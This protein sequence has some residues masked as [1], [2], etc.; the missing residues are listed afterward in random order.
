MNV[1]FKFEGG[2]ELAK[3]L[4]ELPRRTSRQVQREALRAGADPVRSAAS[5]N[6]VRRAGRP[7]LADEM[8]IGNARSKARDE[9]VVAVG[10]NKEERTDQERT[11]DVQGFFVEYG[12]ADTPA[13]AFLR[14]SL[15]ELPRSLSIIRERLWHALVSRGFSTRS[16][17]GSG[18]T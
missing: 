12:T 11:F 4:S 3:T 17:P 10:P 15:S 13:Q 9:V 18:L 2:S 5:R 6:A 1:S 16:T 8:V 7:D 14:P